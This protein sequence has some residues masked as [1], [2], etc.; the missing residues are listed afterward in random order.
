MISSLFNVFIVLYIRNDF[1]DGFFLGTLISFIFRLMQVFPLSFIPELNE[2]FLGC[3]GLIIV[4]TFAISTDSLLLLPSQLLT[5]FD[6]F[7]IEV[8]SRYSLEIGLIRKSSYP[9]DH[10]SHKLML[11]PGSHKFNIL[12]SGLSPRLIWLRVRKELFYVF[13]KGVRND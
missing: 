4:I 12:E 10:L 3:S 7:R 5:L 2:L 1:R 13:A 8:L 6:V 11:N 9:V